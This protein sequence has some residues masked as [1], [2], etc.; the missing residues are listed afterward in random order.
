MSW[1]LSKQSH[2]DPSHLSVT[3]TLCDVF[4]LPLPL[5]GRSHNDGDGDDCVFAE[6]G[7]LFFFFFFSRSFW[8]NL[9]C[10]LFEGIKINCFFPPEK[11]TW[12]LGS[13]SKHPTF[14]WN[15]LLMLWVALDCTNPIYKASNTFIGSRFK[16][17]YWRRIMSHILE[18]EHTYLGFICNEKYWSQSSCFINEKGYQLNKW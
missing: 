3:L 1:N 2:T 16:K 12:L 10:F 11:G 8:R 4:Y 14:R 17:L 13:S 15:Y 9:I 5:T 6:R 7:V 18:D